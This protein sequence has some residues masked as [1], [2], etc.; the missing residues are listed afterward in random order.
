MPASRPAR[1]IP[2]R[3]HIELSRGN[4]VRVTVVLGDAELDAY[5]GDLAAAPRASS[6]R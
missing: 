5:L 4:Q 3:L 1:R 6:R 2:T